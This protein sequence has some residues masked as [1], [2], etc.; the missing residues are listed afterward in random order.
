MKIFRPMRI[1]LSK[2]YYA[3]IDAIDLPLVAK[4]KWYAFVD[5][6]TVYAHHKGRKSGTLLLH[7]VILNA[8]RHLQVD[9]R[10]GNGLNNKRNNL[11]LATSSQ[12]NHNRHKIK[13]RSG[14]QGVKFSKNRWEARINIDKKEIYLG[15]FITKEQATIVRELAAKR[16]FGEFAQ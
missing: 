3:E 8:P 14:V 5:R 1:Q 6:N 15:R 16:Y 9:H 11:R 10:D 2:G 7:R 4:Y 12:N 13:A